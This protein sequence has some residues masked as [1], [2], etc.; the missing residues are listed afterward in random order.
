MLLLVVDT[1]IQPPLPIGGGIC[2][3]ASW[4]IKFCGIVTTCMYVSV[5]VCVCMHI[6]MTMLELIHSVM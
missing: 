3:D 6:C 2:V 5:C 4:T 1:S